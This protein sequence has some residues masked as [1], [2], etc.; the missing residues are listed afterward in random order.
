MGLFGGTTLQVS[1]GS[2]RT[3][4][5]RYSE[6][7]QRLAQEARDDLSKVMPEFRL[8]MKQV[9]KLDKKDVLEIKSMSNPPPLV[10]MVMECVC[11]RPAPATEGRAFEGTA[12]HSMVTSSISC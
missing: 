8:A 12:L 11:V 5:L 6:R 7:V 2:S 3:H 9:E 4:T 10:Q 1:A